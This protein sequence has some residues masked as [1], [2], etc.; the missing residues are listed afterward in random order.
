MPTTIDL[1]QGAK[2]NFGHIENC[3]DWMS[4]M[5]LFIKQAR[6][7]NNERCTHE[8]LPGFKA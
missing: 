4:L 1:H 6:Q 2:G 7:Q 5:S 8:R 3:F